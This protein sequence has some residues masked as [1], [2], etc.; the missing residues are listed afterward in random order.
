[1]LVERP[2]ERPHRN[3]PK[4][5]LRMA[6]RPA[7]SVLR[8]PWLDNERVR[9]GLG[10]DWEVRER[11]DQPPRAA[12]LPCHCYAFPQSVRRTSQKMVSLTMVH[13]ISDNLTLPRP[14]AIM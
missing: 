3:R 7:Q 4:M 2:H 12:R 1:M 11:V 5:S 13:D 14:N 8:S 9:R 10:Q 6:S